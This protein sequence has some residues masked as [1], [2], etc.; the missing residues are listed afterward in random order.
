MTHDENTL[1]AAIDAAFLTNGDNYSASLVTSKHR[2]IYWF[3]EAPARLAVAKAFLAALPPAEQSAEI[4]KLKAEPP[5]E[6]ILSWEPAVGDVVRLKSG[7]PHTTVKNFTPNGLTDCSW[8]DAGGQYH[9][10]KIPTACLEPVRKEASQEA[11]PYAEQSEPEV[12]PIC[13]GRCGIYD[14]EPDSFTPC[15]ACGGTGEEWQWECL[16]SNPEQPQH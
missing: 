10:T 14:P 3:D 7:G 9:Q 4:E 16:N 11:D 15:A 1:Q 13:K 5:A 6:P 8:F 2:T 12:C